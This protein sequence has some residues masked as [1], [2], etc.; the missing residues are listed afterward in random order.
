MIVSQCYS[1]FANF[2]IS[3]SQCFAISVSQVSQ[4]IFC[5]F[6]KDQLSKV[7]QI[8]VSQFYVCFAR[9]T[10]ASTSF[11]S[12]SQMQVSQGF[13]NRYF[14]SQGFASLAVARFL[15]WTVCWCKVNSHCLMPDIA[16]PFSTDSE[17]N[18]FF[19][20]KERWVG[21]LPRAL[22][23]LDVICTV[24]FVVRQELPAQA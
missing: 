23:R 19:K 4:I 14:V 20:P 24:A 12:L 21:C 3:V 5:K 6:H 7:S 11:H 13:A 22:V 10:I 17:L 18:P 9:F 16:C 8:Q 1:N 2:A 15:Q